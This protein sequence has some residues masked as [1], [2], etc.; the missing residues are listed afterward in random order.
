MVT[1]IQRAPEENRTLPLPH[2]N[3]YGYRTRLHW[4]CSHT[5]PDD[6][7]VEFGCGTGYGITYPLL[8]WGYDIV[9]IDIDEPSIEFG[10][11]LLAGA[12]IAGE[13][14]FARDLT[15]LPGPFDV[16]IAS[17]VLEH[18]P[19]ADLDRIFETVWAKLKPGGRFLVTVPNGY[20]WFELES[21]L[22]YRAKLGLVLERSRFTAVVA[23]VKRMLFSGPPGDVIRTTLSPS[24]HVQRFTLKR[25]CRILTDAGFTIVDRQGSVL[26]CGPFSHTFFTGCATIQRLNR[27]LGRRWPQVAAGFYL[28]ARKTPETATSK[29]LVV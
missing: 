16:V 1:R 10:R 28:A 20:G 15:D 6:H 14:L 12:G 26:F 19:R 3:I 5:R 25:I 17:E 27:A 13:V 8:T 7:L 22:W 18:L 21:F 9:G 11:R 23:R 29:R 2:E 24:P 4:M